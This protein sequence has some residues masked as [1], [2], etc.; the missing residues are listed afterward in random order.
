MPLLY[1]INMCFTTVYT[2]EKHL[3]FIGLYRHF[4]NSK[5]LNIPLF[6]PENNTAVAQ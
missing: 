6:Y 2:T 4:S 1:I 3:Y 5:S